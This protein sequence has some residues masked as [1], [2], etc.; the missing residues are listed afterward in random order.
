MRKAELLSPAGCY[1][2]FIGAV[3]A[4]ADAVYLSGRSYGARA[5]AEN[6]DDESLVSVIDIAHLFNIKV[7]LTVN[8]LF[9]Q[10]ET[11]LLPVYLNEPYKHHLDGVIVQDTGAISCIN[12]HFPDLPIH[13]STQLSS[14]CGFSSDIFK[15]YNVTRIVPARELSLDETVA[16]KNSSGLEI[17]SFIHGAMCYSYSGRCLFSS[18][19]GGRSGNRGRCAQPCRLPYSVN[20][21][22]DKYIL[23]MS[24]MC[25]LNILD[26]LIESG[27]DSFKIEGRM[28]KPEYAAGVTAIYRKYINRYYEGT[29]DKIEQEDIEFIKNL[30]L[31]THISEGYYH[32]HNSREMLCIDSP[33]Y[34]GTDDQILNSVNESYISKKPALKINI[35]ISIKKDRPIIISALYKE[36]N[37]SVKG[38]VPDAAKSSP[39]DSKTIIKQ[40][41]KT[42]DTFFVADNIDVDLDE[43]LFMNV[44]AINGLRRSVLDQLKEE[45]IKCNINSMSK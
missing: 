20:D 44:A 13:L 19:L 24:D 43:G 22:K 41:N 8:T 29:F 31:R 1:D 16:L 5:Y 21:L 34:N 35:S 6:F 30:Y 37:V 36:I 27:I 23:S 11:E 7:Y 33:S 25:T 40:L 42:G 2:A 14:T 12:R 39:L 15:K 10:N 17:E 38:P 3:N 4:G 28:K 32:I 9:K 18:I 45:I 26:E